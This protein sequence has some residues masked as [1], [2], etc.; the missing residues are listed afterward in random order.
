[1]VYEQGRL[2]EAATR[3]DGETGENVT[4]NALEV[5]S[6]P[7]VIPD[8]SIKRIEVRGEIIFE[9]AK[10][11]ELN[12]ARISKGEQPFA[13]P[14]N[15]A[16]GS[17][18][19]LDPKITAERPLTFYAYQ[20]LSSE[21]L[22]F[23]SQSGMHRYLKN[24]GFTVQSDTF[25][26]T[27]EEEVLVAYR[28][29]LQG[30]ANL[31]FEIDGLVVKVDSLAAQEQLGT[32]TRTPRWAVAF[33]FPPS[34]EMTQI[35]DISVQVGRT[36]V[37]TPVA[38]LR[39]V[40]IGGVLVKRATLHNEEEIARKDI[41]I[42]DT[43]VVR[44]QGDV[45]PAVVSVVTAK[46]TGTERIFS[47]PTLCPSCGAEVTKDKD[48]VFIR[49][50]NLQCPAQLLERLCHF[51]SRTAFNIDSLGEKGLE[52]LINAGLIE[53]AADLF[54]LKREELLSL[55]RMGERSVQNL[56]EAIERAKIVPLHRLIYALGIPQV[57]ERTAKDL[58]KRFGSLE[59]FRAASEAELLE[60]ED[61]GPKVATSVLRYL[62]RSQAFIDKLL[63]NGVIP[64]VSL[65]DNSANQPFAGQVIVVTGTLSK[66]SRDEVK[67]LIEKLGGKTVSSVSKKTTFLIAGEDAGSKLEKAR[68][69]G[70]KVLDEEEFLQ[71]IGALS[72]TEPLFV[73]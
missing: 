59:K 68:E 3:G 49:C 65:D 15:A 27:S 73:R 32:R 47:L 56:L 38:E 17:V 5:A 61:V 43:V 63:N 4:R 16:A 44:R 35:L 54:T 51:V 24:L 60:V 12:E 41:R 39:P 57:G 71:L 18:R 42:G 70:V 58:S 9:I 48:G 52:Q 28:R 45:I 19:Q 25:S 1:V 14:R 67:T 26:A 21:S 50:D 11:E 62:E 2:I 22:P 31:P 23:D 8:S 40:R 7:H 13:N 72:P 29:L 37:L 46:R 20:A 33:K 34:E 6:I 10:F 53:D 64:E 36:G 69:L 55:D 30:R 66:F